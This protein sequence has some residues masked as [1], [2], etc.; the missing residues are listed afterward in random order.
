MNENV[1]FELKLENN[2]KKIIPSNKKF[3]D[4]CLEWILA[5]TSH[6]LVYNSNVF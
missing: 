1:D 5:S 3:K 6:G 2:M 4:L